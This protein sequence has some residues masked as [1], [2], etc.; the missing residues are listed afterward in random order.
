MGLDVKFFPRRRV[1]VK[2]RHIL[3]DGGHKWMNEL[4]LQYANE[5]FYT[6]E[7]YPSFELGDM[8]FKMKDS[9][10]KVAESVRGESWHQAIE[11]A[12]FLLQCGRRRVSAESSY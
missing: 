6:K 5:S 8:G 11:V 9:L 12:E 1:D 4:V 3:N 2:F 7:R 10:S